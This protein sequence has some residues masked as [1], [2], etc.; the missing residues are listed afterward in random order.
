[1][2]HG[3]L[4]NNTKIGKSQKKSCI[5]IQSVMFYCLSWFTFSVPSCPGMLLYILDR[6]IY[7]GL[8]P[9]WTFSQQITFFLL[10]E[11]LCLGGMFTE[12]KLQSVP[13][14]DRWEDVWMRKEEDKTSIVQKNWTKRRISVD[15]GLNILYAGVT[16]WEE[17]MCERLQQTQPGRFSKQ[18]WL[19]V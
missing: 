9:V 1:M 13:V 4:N 16:S 7:R 17:I 10:S 18:A 11:Q 19:S 2:Q 5:T 12:L 14:L 8:F 15:R 3:T 6:F